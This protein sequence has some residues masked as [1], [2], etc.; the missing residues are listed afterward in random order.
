MFYLKYQCHAW[1]TIS[2]QLKAMF[3]AFLG[4]SMHGSQWHLREKETG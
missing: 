2:T 3:M 1:F 4:M